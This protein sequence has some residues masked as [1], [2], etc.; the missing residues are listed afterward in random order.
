MQQQ[1]QLDET[2]VVFSGDAGLT[3]PNSQDTARVQ[4]TN[5]TITPEDDNIASGSLTVQDSVAFERKSEKSDLL[6]ASLSSLTLP[7]YGPFIDIGR[8]YH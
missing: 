7:G 3:F 6:E 1:A 8:N 5:F 4:F 2:G